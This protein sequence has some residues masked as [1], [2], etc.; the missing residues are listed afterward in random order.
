MVTWGRLSHEQSRREGDSSGTQRPNFLACENDD[1]VLALGS[2]TVRRVLVMH[3][4]AQHARVLCEPL[5]SRPRRRRASHQAQRAFRRGAGGVAR[6]PSS[7]AE[8]ESPEGDLAPARCREEDVA[9]VRRVVQGKVL[10][11]SRRVSVATGS[12]RGSLRDHRGL[13]AKGQGSSDH[14]RRA[15]S[16][17]FRPLVC[18]AAL[19]NREPSG[20]PRASLMPMGTAYASAARFSRVRPLARSDWFS[21]TLRSLTLVGVTSTHSVSSACSRACSSVRMR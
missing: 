3:F 19:I 21:V 1:E 7:R 20:R 4:T 16:A 8:P 18:G 9:A 5:F 15:R 17:S 14:S 13:A 11:E 10:G 6:C 2:R 12:S